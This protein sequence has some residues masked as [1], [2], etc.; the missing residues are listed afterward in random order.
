MATLANLV[1]RITGNTASLN[2]AVGKAEGRMEKFKR[3]GSRALNAVKTAAKGLAVGG[4]IAV[5]GFG[6]SLVKSLIDTEKELRPMVERARIGAESLQVLA[7]AATRAGSEDGLEAIVDSSQELQLQLGELALTGNARAVPA[8]ENLGLVAENLQKMEPEAAFRA[9]LTELQKIPNVA[10]RAIA[11]EEIFG[12]TSE[13]LSGI[14]NLTAAEFAGLEQNVRATTDIWSQD[15]LDS[16]KG[17]DEAL[18]E[19]K[20]A[21]TSLVTP[22]IASLLPALTNFA[23]WVSDN[24]P[25]ILGFFTGVKDAAAPF[26][27]AFATGFGVIFPI[28]KSFVTFIFTN[29]PLLIAAILAIGAAIVLSLG[30]VSAGAAAI[31]GI[32]IAIGF[33][34][35]NW[36]EVWDSIIRVFRSAAGFITGIYT[37]KFGW[38]LPFGPL[39]KGILFIKDNWRT[40]WEGMQGVLERVAEVIRRVIDGIM[41]AVRN[42]TGAVST[43]ANVAGSI[44]SG[45][46][47][48]I[49]GFAGGVTNFPGRHGDGGRARAG[50]GEPAAR[51]QRDANRRGPGRRPDNLQRPGVRGRRLPRGGQQG[52]SGLGAGGERVDGSRQYTVW[53]CQRSKLASLP[54]GVAG[55][56]HRR[57]AWDGTQLVVV[58]DQRRR[59]YGHWQRNAM[60]GLIHAGQCLVSEVGQLPAGLSAAAQGIALGMDTQLAHLRTD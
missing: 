58:D 35:D 54:S 30:P 38:L 18:K 8:L 40:V 21:I 47:S 27:S 2:K 13:K 45:I 19:M 52:P 34:K 31:A 26:F 17:F 49:P 22:F 56:P 46:R 10:D 20:G 9:V 6:I 59:C 4:A 28:L 44:G 60:T 33:L 5:A 39:V 48:V 50:A 32:I 7:E 55:T 16:A 24:R 37:S 15:A 43:V 14:I 29:K 41:S 42:V 36:E 23:N 1:V 51:V 12:G 57:D 3:A 11:A 25:Q 53:Q